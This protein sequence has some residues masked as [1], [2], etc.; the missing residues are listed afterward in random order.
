MAENEI[1][2][3][4]TGTV[5]DPNPIEDPISNILAA[6]KYSRTVYPWLGSIRGEVI[7]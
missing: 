7:D 2:P 3:V 6:L 1:S 4:L 5:L